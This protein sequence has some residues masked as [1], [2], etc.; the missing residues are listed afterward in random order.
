LLFLAAPACA[1][2]S[3]DGGWSP[4]VIPSALN[5]KPVEVS[6]PEAVFIGLRNNRA[7]KSEYMQRVVDKFALH[8]AEAQFYNPILNLNSSVNMARVSGVR[9]TASNFSPTVT[10]QIPTGAAFTFAWNN[11]QANV[12]GSAP[13][14]SSQPILQ[15][16]QPLLQGGGVEVATAPLRIARI[17]EENN[18][19]TLRTTVIS[20]ITSIISAYYQLVQARDQLKLAEASLKRAKDLLET[21][22]AL[23]AAG[24]LAS[25]ELVQT[26]ASITQ[27]ELIVVQARNGYD[28]A[29]LALLVLLGLNPASQIA[30]SETPVAVP[31]RIDLG[32]ALKVAYDNQPAYLSQM[33]TIKINEINLIVAKNARLW[34]LQL[35]GGTG[36]T[37]NRET[38]GGS[39]PA[40]PRTR[41]D[42]NIGLNLTTTI[43]D[44]VQ[45]QLEVNATIALHQSQLLLDQIRDQL[46]QQVSDAVRNVETQRQS[47]EIARKNRELSQQKL[48]IELTKLQVGRSSNFEVVTFQNDLLNAQSTELGA[49]IAYLT[50]LATLDQVLGTTL[51][52]WRISLND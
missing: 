35:T 44:P 28:T 14:S 7:I 36:Q 38:L 41:A 9:T 11:V 46:A 29:R 16:V 13:T 19:L 21:N 45:E 2:G 48:D 33:L 37:V 25:V 26:D 42:F 3:N 27:Q 31:V 34:N 10:W 43:N 24:R 49:V 1:A 50:A 30:P 52:T 6:L 22:K 32:R 18:K 12:R 15:V 4:K 47:V 8:V 5:A 51:D 17:N 20:N 23:V 40:L 39:I